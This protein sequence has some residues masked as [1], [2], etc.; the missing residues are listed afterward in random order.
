MASTGHWPVLGGDSPPGKDEALECLLAPVFM[1][2]TPSVPSGQWPDGT[3][4]SP[5]PPFRISGFFRI[6]TVGFRI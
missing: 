3:G 1:G 6:S 2:S 5:V 4:E